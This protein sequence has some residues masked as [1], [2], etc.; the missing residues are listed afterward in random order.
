MEIRRD[1]LLTSFD[2]LNFFFFSTNR[3]TAFCGSLNFNRGKKALLIGL[4]WASAH[5]RTGCL[6]MAD[7]T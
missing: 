6:E 5:C 4:W 7:L 2:V 1:F 3:I